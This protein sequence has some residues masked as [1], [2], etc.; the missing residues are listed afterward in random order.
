MEVV[1]VVCAVIAQDKKVLCALRS[2]H[3]STPLHWEFPG[4]KVEAFETHQQALKRELLEELNVEV[5]VLDFIITSIHSLSET[6]TLHLHAYH[7]SIAHGIAEAKEH[8]ELR[9]IKPEE[10][11]LLHWA[12]ADIPIVRKVEHEF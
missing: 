11:S 1:H 8:D 3:M 7:C 12:P 2:E 4:G 5:E 9:W 6:K 10:L